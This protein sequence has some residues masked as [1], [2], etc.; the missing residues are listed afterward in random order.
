MALQPNSHD[1]SPSASSVEAPDHSLPYSPL[2]LHP[3]PCTNT[4]YT[5]SFPVTLPSDTTGPHFLRSLKQPK[6]TSPGRSKQKSV[7]TTCVSTWIST[8]D[9]G[10]RRGKPHRA[11]QQRGGGQNFRA[12]PV[13]FHFGGADS[14]GFVPKN[15]CNKNE[16]NR[17]QSRVLP[18]GKDNSLGPVAVVLPLAQNS[19]SA[20]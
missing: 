15:S 11:K 10:T 3:R 6:K 12:F 19:G 16:E 5:P 8:S 13:F 2:S 18:P 14:R 4:P 7:P 1:T 9:L 17:P 20:S